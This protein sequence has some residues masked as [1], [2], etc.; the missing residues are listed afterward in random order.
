MALGFW[1]C[2]AQEPDKLVEMRWNERN[3]KEDADGNWVLS[4]TRRQAQL[5]ADGPAAGKAL[6]REGEW[7]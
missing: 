5:N 4:S 3:L 2:E 7:R 1:L 6:W